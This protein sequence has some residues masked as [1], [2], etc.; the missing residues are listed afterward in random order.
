LDAT[1]PSVLTATEIPCSGCG[2]NVTGGTA[3]GQELFDEESARAYGDARFAARRRMLVDT[4]CLQHPNRYWVSAISIAAHLTGLCV[5]VERRDREEPLNAAL[6]RWLSRRPRLDKPA[7]PHDRGDLII[8]DVR[9]AADPAEH[10]GAA[11]A[12]AHATWAA[13]APLHD[14]ARRWI[15]QVDPDRAR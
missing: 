1:G 5:A 15:A 12:W 13:Y 2:L 9:L 8:A 11:E 3:G 10:A 6:Q 14:I 4:Y 7:P